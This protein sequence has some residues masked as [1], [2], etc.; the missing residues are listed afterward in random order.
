[1]YEITKSDKP[2]YL[3]KKNIVDNKTLKR[4]GQSWQ[5]GTDNIKHFCFTDEWKN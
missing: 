2:S 4:H 3:R 5:T 1:M